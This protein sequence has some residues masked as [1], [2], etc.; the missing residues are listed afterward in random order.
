MNNSSQSLSHPQNDL[1]LEPRVSQYG[2]HMVM[3]NV[4]RPTNKHLV[5]IDTRFTNEYGYNKTTYNTTHNY[6]ITLP[7]KIT[8]VKSLR[9]VTVDIPISYY[10]ISSSLGNNSFLITDED[11]SSVKKQVIITD[12]NYSS[13]TLLSTEVY[14]QINA[15]GGNFTDVSFS[16]DDNTQ[17]SQWTVESTSSK[18]FTLDFNV[19]TSGNIDKYDFRSKL[20]WMLG[21]R[22]VSYSSIETSSVLYSESIINLHSIRYLYLVLDEFSSNFTNSFVSP[23]FG[24]I[25]NK[26]ILARISISDSIYPFGSTLNG[27]EYNGTLVSDKREYH[28]KLDIQRISIELVTEI[29]V[30]INLNGLD[31]SFVLEIFH[32]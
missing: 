2:S 17:Y 23:Q 21:F 15:L 3:S 8:N 25:M 14:N 4:Y 27:H 30:P 16:I 26:K 29:G 22:D 5:N 24:Y 19:D 6:T 20:G 18:K 1:F 9:A 11:D 28:G 31:F 13:S 7:E 32:E 10:N 12:G